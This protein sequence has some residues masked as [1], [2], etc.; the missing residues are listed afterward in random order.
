MK[1]LEGT[2]MY[3]EERIFEEIS[4][5]VTELKKLELLGHLSQ[6]QQL[7]DLQGLQN[8]E[9]LKF[10]PLTNVAIGVI[11]FFN[12]ITLMLI[13]RIISRRRN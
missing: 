9:L 11:T 5:I 4:K 3:C 7:E 6:L 12:L 8:L 1:P 10:A 2:K 13:L